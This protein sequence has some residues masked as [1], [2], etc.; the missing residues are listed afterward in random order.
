MRVPRN[1]QVRIVETLRASDWID[2]VHIDTVQDQAA[3]QLLAT[4]TDKTW[5]LADC[6]SFVVMKERSITAAL[7]TD[8][9]FEQAGFARLLK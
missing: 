4:H 9:H 3:W 8:H 5:S 7:T 2:V 1:E 6:A